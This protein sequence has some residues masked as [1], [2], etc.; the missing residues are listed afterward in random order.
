[1]ALPANIRVNLSA[2]FPALV[3]GG[4]GIAV[5]KNNGV[6]TISLV[7][8]QLVSVMQAAGFIPSFSGSGLL[9]FGA[10][11]G[12]TD[13]QLVITG[14]TAILAGSVVEAFLLPAATADHSIDEHWLD[15]PAVMAGN[16]VPG[17]GF[18]IYGNARFQMTGSDGLLTYGKWNVGWRWQ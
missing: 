2:P 5:A 17:T 3:I 4:G 1:M 12:A 16:I 18:T 9:D 7:S 6:W 14:Q 15:G 10:F 11:P 8:G 13:V